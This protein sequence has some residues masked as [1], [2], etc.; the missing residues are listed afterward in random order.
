MSRPLLWITTAAF[1]AAATVVTSFGPFF[2][3]LFL[4]MVLPLVVRGDSLVG[5]SGLFTGFGACWTFL[6]A[7]Q[8]SSG[9]TLDNADFWSAVGV[10][11]L[12]IGAALLLVIAGR[13][14]GARVR[15]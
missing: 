5:L 8:D 2:A 13:G 14:T 11:P 4:L 15:H 12:V 7:R 10:V 9:G 6:L 3:V 1:G